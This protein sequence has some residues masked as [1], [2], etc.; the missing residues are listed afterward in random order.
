M[1]EPWRHLLVRICLQILVRL[2]SQM[3]EPAAVL[4]ATA[5]AN[6]ACMLAI[7]SSSCI[8]FFG[9]C[10][11][12]QIDE[13]QQLLHLFI[14]QLCSQMADL[15][16]TALAEAPS[17]AMFPDSRAAGSPVSAPCVSMLT[18]ALA[19]AA[20]AFS[21]SAVMPADGRVARGPEPLPLRAGL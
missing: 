12:R 14:S 7:R 17:A 3:A 6:S 8:R 18:E 19:A 15:A 16:A 1:A 21:S 4:K 20:P 2:C 11:R 9:A 5:L 10:A 13:P